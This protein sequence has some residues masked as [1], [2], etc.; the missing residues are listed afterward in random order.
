MNDLGNVKVIFFDEN[1]KK[2]SASGNGIDR[3]YYIEINLNPSLKRIKF[4]TV[5]IPWIRIQKVIVYN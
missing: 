5:L 1:Q 3:G 4:N 2:K